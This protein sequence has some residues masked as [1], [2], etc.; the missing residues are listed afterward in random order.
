MWA[1]FLSWEIE[2][3]WWLCM[4]AYLS[5]NELLLAN[6]WT[7]LSSIRKRIFSKNVAD[8]LGGCLRSSRSFGSG[9]VLHAK[10]SLQLSNTQHSGSM[11]SVRPS[12]SL[13]LSSL[14]TISIA[15]SQARPVQPWLQT[16]W[17]LLYWFA[18]LS[19]T[20]FELQLFG[21]LSLI[22]K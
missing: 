16:Q 12:L 5:E 14:Q 21:Q 6:D 19:H 13:S 8:K 9:D 11:Q 18:L 17:Y 20:P 4:Y 1:W 7:L 10:E 15:I 3:V 2:S 22:R